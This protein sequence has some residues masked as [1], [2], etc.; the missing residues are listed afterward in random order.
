MES[1]VPS[2]VSGRPPLLQLSDLLQRQC[3]Q[4]S[5]GSQLDELLPMRQPI[6]PREVPTEFE[7]G[8]DVE[9]YPPF[10]VRG[11]KQRILFR[12]LAVLLAITVPL[13]GSFSYWT[14]S[15]FITAT[16]YSVL[17]SIP[18]VALVHPLF[19]NNRLAG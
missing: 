18:F 1:M 6:P 13:I 19:L 3:S 10:G 15:P 12:I 8:Q 9:S 17:A 7:G 2:Q 4:S 16:T 11:R 14:P 5:H